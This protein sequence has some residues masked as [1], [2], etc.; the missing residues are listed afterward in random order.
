MGPSRGDP[1][2][3][4]G[5]TPKQTELTVNAPDAQPPAQILGASR[6]TVP[7]RVHRR[8]PGSIQ[9]NSRPR[10]PQNSNHG[11]SPP[12][13]RPSDMKDPHPLATRKYAS[14][15]ALPDA[16]HLRYRNKS[17]STI[18]ESQLIQYKQ[19]SDHLTHSQSS[20]NDD[21]ER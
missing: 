21:V 6:I 11:R 13:V 15:A 1:D 14:Q 5:W 2:F 3:R 7:P 10:N 12:R 20:V 19:S 16:E 17:P 8:A 9:D 18:K 4:D